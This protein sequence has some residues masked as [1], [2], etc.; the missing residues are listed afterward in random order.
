M[1]MV[2]HTKKTLSSGSLYAIDKYKVNKDD[3]LKDGTMFKFN[4]N[5]KLVD[6]R[7]MEII[8]GGRLAKYNTKKL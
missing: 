5:V 8:L 7:K 1:R 4:A 6:F 3:E 2:W